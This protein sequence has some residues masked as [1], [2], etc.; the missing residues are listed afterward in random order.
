M[1]GVV[2]LVDRG[3]KRGLGM[4]AGLRGGGSLVGASDCSSGW[5]RE[6]AMNEIPSVTSGRDTEGIVADRS[7]G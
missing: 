3:K 5:G 2:L 6:E 4:S 1:K 7:E